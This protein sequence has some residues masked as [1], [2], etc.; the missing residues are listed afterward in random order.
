[1]SDTTNT[2][3]ARHR[4]RTLLGFSIGATLMV[5]VVL[6]AFVLPLIHS[7][8]H[9][10]PLGVVAPEPAITAVDTTL[11]DQQWQIQPYA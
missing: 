3:P 2:A 10:V 1:M 7:G 9:Q 5:L 6:S 4:A 11:D 8:P